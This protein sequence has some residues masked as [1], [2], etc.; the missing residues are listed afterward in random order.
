MTACPMPIRQNESPRK[1][2]ARQDCLHRTGRKRGK[3]LKGKWLFMGWATSTETS[4][5]G[6]RVSQPREYDKE[7]RFALAQKRFASGCALGIDRGNFANHRLNA[8]LFWGQAGFAAK[9]SAKIF[10]GGKPRFLGH[11]GKRA[12]A[13]LQKGLGLRQANLPDYFGWAAF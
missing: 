6:F 9:R 13:V 4:W 8:V 3:D 7:Q 10:Q 1:I 11:F 2:S 5:D 12:G